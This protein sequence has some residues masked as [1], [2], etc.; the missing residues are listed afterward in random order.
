MKHR[1]FGET[2]NP[3]R[4]VFAASMAPNARPG[5]VSGVGQQD[6]IFDLNDVFASK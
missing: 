5:S 1:T 4:E 3:R 6:R 2:V